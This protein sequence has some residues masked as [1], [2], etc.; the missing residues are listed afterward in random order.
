[1]LPHQ[2]PPPAKAAGFY[3]GLGAPT[4]ARNTA[5]LSTDATNTFEEFIYPAG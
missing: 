2:R 4:A 3:Y 1:M 5:T